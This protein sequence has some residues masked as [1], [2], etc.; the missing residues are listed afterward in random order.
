MI[1]FAINVKMLT[2]LEDKQYLPFLACC[3][4]F[5]IAT[6]KLKFQSILQTCSC[7][8]RTLPRWKNIILSQSSIINSATHYP[9]PVKPCTCDSPP[10]WFYSFLAQRFL[11][12]APGSSTLMVFIGSSP[13]LKS[14]SYTS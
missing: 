4:S 8:E 9:N 14:K 10:G 13:H 5:V 1:T 6:I 7:T 12:A 11:A 3:C 2:S